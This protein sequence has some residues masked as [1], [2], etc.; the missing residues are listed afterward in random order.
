MSEPSNVAVVDLLHG[1]VPLGVEEVDTSDDDSDV[2]VIQ[3]HVGNVQED[4]GEMIIAVAEQ[5][6][7]AIDA[8]PPENE[9][10]AAPAASEAEP[11]IFDFPRAKSIPLSCPGQCA[12]STQRGGDATQFLM[13]GVLQRSKR[14]SLTFF[15]IDC[16]S[17]MV[18]PC[19][20]RG[21]T[22][23]A[24]GAGPLK[25]HPMMANDRE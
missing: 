4:L 18:I 11:P 13:K 23:L 3:D 5:G 24:G 9:A 22:S 2:Q 6:E 1:L 7:G 10:L 25:M 14:R 20:R 15:P 19:G 16:T 8:V 21:K 17:P 12:N